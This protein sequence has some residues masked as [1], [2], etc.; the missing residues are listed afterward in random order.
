MKG[1]QEFMLYPDRVD[2]ILQAIERARSRIYG[3][4]ARPR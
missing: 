2:A 1:F 3:T 4:P